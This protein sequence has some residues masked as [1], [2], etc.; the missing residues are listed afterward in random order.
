MHGLSFI[1]THS[2]PDRDNFVKIIAENIRPGHE[3]QFET[4]H[5]APCMR[6]VQFPYECDS[7]MHYTPR[8]FSKNSKNTL[9]LY[10]VQYKN[11]Y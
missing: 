11:L 8:E 1:H 10:C 6:A 7:I 3:I 5:E 4:C 2:R 9:F